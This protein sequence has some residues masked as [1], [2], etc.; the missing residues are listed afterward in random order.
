VYLTTL[1]KINSIY[2]HT[3]LS[4]IN[5]G[6][7]KLFSR[8]LTSGSL[9]DD[10][11]QLQQFLNAHSVVLASIGPGSPGNET[12]KFGALTKAALKMF[13]KSNNLTETGMFDES[14]RTLVNQMVV[15]GR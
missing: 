4:A 14:T 1:R 15:E 7:A 13:Q 6:T 11:K 8:N 10:V 2:C 12:T 5:L 3:S 9:G